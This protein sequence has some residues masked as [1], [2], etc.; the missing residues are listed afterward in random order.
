MNS[1]PS[2][3]QEYVARYKDKHSTRIPKWAPLIES[4]EKT[5]EFI[6]LKRIGTYYEFPWGFIIENELDGMLCVT[7][8]PIE[9][10]DRGIGGLQERYL[11][12]FVEVIK[13]D[14]KVFQDIGQLDTSTC[15]IFFQDGRPTMSA[16]SIAAAG[17]RAGRQRFRNWIANRVLMDLWYDVMFKVMDPNYKFRNDKVFSKA[18][19]KPNQFHS[20]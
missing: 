5:E 8:Y 10:L 1:V 7:F 6:V 12:A 3:N 19:I 20:F 18:T 9:A 14:I 16:F 17:D 2:A 4:I 15:Q 11:T 13:P